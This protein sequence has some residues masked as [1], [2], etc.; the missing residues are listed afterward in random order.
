[1]LTGICMQVYAGIAREEGWWTDMA[2]LHLQ[3]YFVF[4]KMYKCFYAPVV[5]DFRLFDFNVHVK[6]IYSSGTIQ[7]YMYNFIVPVFRSLVM[8]DVVAYA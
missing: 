3:F 8:L 6:V 4:N 1:M 5:L 2:L 7:E